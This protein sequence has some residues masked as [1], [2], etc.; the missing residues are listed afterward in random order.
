MLFILPKCRTP[1]VADPEF[2]SGAESTLSG[3]PT[4]DFA[5]YSQ[6]LHEIEIIR[7]PSGACV[8]HAPHLDPTMLMAL[9]CNMQQKHPLSPVY[10]I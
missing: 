4:Y 3:M 5:K 10:P 2:P 7:T 1:L 9:L 6:K 8:P